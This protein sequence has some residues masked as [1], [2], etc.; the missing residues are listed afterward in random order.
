M[1]GRG[2]PPVVARSSWLFVLISP[3]FLDEIVLININLVRI[4]GNFAKLMV[5]L[6]DWAQESL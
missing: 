4:T 6:R 5:L 3:I 1:D 2:D